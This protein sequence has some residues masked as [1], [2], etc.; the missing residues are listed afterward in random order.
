M[1]ACLCAGGGW[2]GVE[3]GVRKGPGVQ[4][5]VDERAGGGG[6]GGL[7]QGRGGQRGLP[8]K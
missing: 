2:V 1:K 5:V 3:G 4:D 8:Q 7:G 6:T